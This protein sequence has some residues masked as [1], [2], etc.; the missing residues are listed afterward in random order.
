MAAKDVSSD[1]Y[2]PNQQAVGQPGPARTGDTAEKASEAD[3]GV[4]D[5]GAGTIDDVKAHVE[6]NPDQR[7]AVL[8]AEKAGKNRSTLVDWLASE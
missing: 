6:A 8:E 5:P 7:G 3:A 2:A 4:F 1:W